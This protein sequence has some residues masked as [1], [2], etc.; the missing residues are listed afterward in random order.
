MIA[1]IRCEVVPAPRRLF[2]SYR[3][4]SSALISGLTKQV[5]FHEQYGYQSQLYSYNEDNALL[6]EQS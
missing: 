1:K 3:D 6:H 2:P 5:Y 4:S